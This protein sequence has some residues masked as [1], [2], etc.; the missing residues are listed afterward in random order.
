VLFVLSDQKIARL[1][2]DQER[3]AS[4]QAA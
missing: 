4:A 1:H 3:V 2:Q